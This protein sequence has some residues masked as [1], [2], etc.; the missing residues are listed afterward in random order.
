MSKTTM[1]NAEGMADEYIQVMQSKAQ[2]IQAAVAIPDMLTELDALK[3]KEI[4]SEAEF[5]AKKK[6]L[7]SRY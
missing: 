7:L 1:L 3:R 5:E 4:I 6:E 2:V